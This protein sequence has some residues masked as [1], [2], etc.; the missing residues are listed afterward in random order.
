MDKF[1][2]LKDL[3]SGMVVCQDNNIPL[4]LVGLSPINGPTDW[5]FISM[6]GVNSNR[7]YSLRHPVVDRLRLY[8]SYLDKKKIPTKILYQ[9][10]LKE[11]EFYSDK[12]VGGIKLTYYIERDIKNYQNS[13]RDYDIQIKNMLAEVDEKINSCLL[14]YRFTFFG[15]R[16]IPTHVNRFVKL[17][18]KRQFEQKNRGK[19][20]KPA[21]ADPKTLE[22][23][24]EIPT[25]DNRPYENIAHQTL[26]SLLER[27]PL[28]YTE[29]ALGWPLFDMALLKKNHKGIDYLAFNLSHL[30]GQGEF[31]FTVKEE[32]G[33]LSSPLPEEDPFP[34]DMR[35]GE[36]AQE[37]TRRQIALWLQLKRLDDLDCV[38]LG[39]YYY[40]K[41]ADAS[42]PKYY[43]KPPEWPEIYQGRMGSV[44]EAFA[45]SGRKSPH[46]GLRYQDWR[47]R[48]NPFVRMGRSVC[49]GGHPYGS[50]RDHKYCGD[51]AVVRYQT[52]W[53]T[54]LK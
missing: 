12:N 20:Y 36:E 34:W 19:M 46:N 51:C 18:R 27:V 49:R 54:N 23:L 7:F 25:P 38:K 50:R 6:E 39:D 17:T 33:I 15:K 52:W 3:T 45:I 22:T 32:G 5:V 9:T 8:E 26:V 35:E 48:P 44:E 42:D 29:P 53:K 2:K 24:S 41:R 28:K 13:L 16:R 1:L 43:P 4:W 47:R 14:N 11:L 21:Y 37:T 30:G 31:K 10:L 40:L